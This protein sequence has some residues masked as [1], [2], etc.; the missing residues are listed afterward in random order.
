MSLMILALA[1][2]AAKREREYRS[3]DEQVPKKKDSSRHDECHSLPTYDYYD[4]VVAEIEEED[5]VLYPFFTMITEKYFALRKEEREQLT[6][7][8]SELNTILY[9]KQTE[10]EQFKRLARFAGIEMDETI[11]DSKTAR[12]EFDGYGSVKIEDG[13]TSGDY[14]EE[15]LTSLQKK[16]ELARQDLSTMDKKLEPLYL[17]MKQLKAEAERSV[18]SK[19]SKLERIKEI[20]YSISAER[21]KYEYRTI[22]EKIDDLEHLI[23]LLETKKDLFE[24]AM[25]EIVS[26]LPL[27]AELKELRQKAYEHS[28]TDHQD[29]RFIEKAVEELTREGKITDIILEKVFLAL[30]KVE[31]KQRRGE[32]EIRPVGYPSPRVF[33]RKMVKWFVKHVYEA[34]ED[35]VQRNYE[36]PEEEIEKPKTYKKD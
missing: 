28:Y 34:D 24:E 19:K 9:S 36:L 6:K 11:I 14:F 30:D 12:V 20:E 26:T 10:Y 31:I 22:S 21:S 2:A 25:K 3:G 8:I 23:H 32:Y 29:E 27:E 1:A 35:F 33:L 5:K 17:E 18:F 7:R 13:T 16:L 4:Y 15:L